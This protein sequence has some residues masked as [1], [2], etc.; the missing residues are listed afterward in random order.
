MVFSSLTFLYLFL[1][2]S[3]VF[4]YVSK[5]NIFR[6]ISLTLFSLIF[7]AWAEPMWIFLMIFTA[8]FDYSMG[9]FIAR[10]SGVLGQKLGLF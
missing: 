3:L 1:P 4:H 6:N 9:L 7:Y 8:F 10:K 2:L 5:N